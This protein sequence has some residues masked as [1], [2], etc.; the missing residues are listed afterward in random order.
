M[1]YS[2]VIV[3]FVIALSIFAGA[4]VAVAQTQ[5]RLTGG[6][7]MHSFSIGDTLPPTVQDTKMQIGIHGEAAR[8]IFNA[9][10]PRSRVADICKS[11]ALEIRDRGDLHCFRDER[12]YFCA[13]GLD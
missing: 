6:Y 12:G 10:G 3:P 2:R 9:L 11:Q 8:D 1:R 13:V 4:V 5:G 7:F